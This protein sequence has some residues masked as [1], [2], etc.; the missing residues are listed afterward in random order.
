MKT[1]RITRLRFVRDEDGGI[2]LY[3]QHDAPGN[4]KETN[5]LPAPEE[6]FSATL[7]LYWAKPEALE[8]TWQL[9]PLRR[10]N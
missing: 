4:D 3:L 2:T 8:G 6:P 1:S 5:G 10:I 7:R 9:P